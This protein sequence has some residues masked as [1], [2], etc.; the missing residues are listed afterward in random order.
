M[1]GEKYKGKYTNDR[2]ESVDAVG[3]IEYVVPGFLGGLRKVLGETPTDT[4]ITMRAEKVPY[5]VSQKITRSPDGVTTERFDN[6]TGEW[7]PQNFHSYWDGNSM[8]F[9]NSAKPV[10]LWWKR[11]T[12]SSVNKKQQGG[13]M[14]QQD[15]TQK[16][17]IKQ[18]LKSVLAAFVQGD[19][20]AQQIIGNLMKENPQGFYQILSELENEGDTNA[21]A[22]KKMIEEQ[23]SQQS[24]GTTT[25]KKGAK[26]NYVK[27]LKGIC[28][29]GYL[30]T[31]GRCKPC[32]AKMKAKGGDM[33][34]VK[35]FKAGRKCKK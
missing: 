2:G 23:A 1:A 22:I 16:D 31:G 17:K 18:Q 26:L 24:G 13:T 25:A 8:E 19:Q 35:S 12:N 15:S 30:K 3:T 20:Q 33:D 14:Q 21:S 5:A 7:I 29:E 11:D 34:P 6:S 4:V 9:Y 27:E 28:P 32:E 10:Q